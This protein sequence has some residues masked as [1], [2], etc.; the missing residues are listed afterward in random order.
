LIHTTSI[1]FVRSDLTVSLV[2]T[3]HS[4]ALPIPTISPRK[5]HISSFQNACFISFFNGCHSFSER[6]CNPTGLSSSLC[7]SGH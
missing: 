5:L 7:C 6:C 1:P 3:V 4:F 2:A